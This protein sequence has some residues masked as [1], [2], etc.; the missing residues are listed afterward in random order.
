[1][2]FLE[3]FYRV[4]S[5]LFGAILSVLVSMWLSFSTLFCLL[6]SANFGRL[7][8]DG[9]TS[10]NPGMESPEEV[11]RVQTRIQSRQQRS[12]DYLECQRGGSSPGKD[13][14]GRTNVTES[15]RTCQNWAASEPHVPKYTDVGKVGDTEAGEHNHCRNPNQNSEGVWCYTTDPGKEWEHC[16]VPMHYGSIPI[17]KMH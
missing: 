1:M 12:A 15:G 14:S 10:G 4:L 13:F 16:S 5:F 3:L 6:L 7:N 17:K 11:K 9:R 8:P 2:Y